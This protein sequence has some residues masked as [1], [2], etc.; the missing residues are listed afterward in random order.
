MGR[1]TA[2]SASQKSALRAHRQ[3]NPYLSDKEFQQWFEQTYNHILSSSSV[4]EIL[5]T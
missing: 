4:S 1:R 2:I 5:S 3:L